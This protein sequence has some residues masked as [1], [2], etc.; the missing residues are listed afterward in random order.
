LSGR[1]TAAS[2]PEQFRRSWKPEQ[3]P[4]LRLIAKQPAKQGNIYLTWL[5]T[6]RR[7]RCLNS[8]RPRTWLTPGALGIQAAGGRSPAISNEGF[9]NTFFSASSRRGV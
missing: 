7:P 9:F 4:R 6:H 5:L 3:L 8:S 1:R 2:R